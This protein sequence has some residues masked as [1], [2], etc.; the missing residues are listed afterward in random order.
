MAKWRRT[1]TQK[2]CAH[3]CFFLIGLHRTLNVTADGWLLSSWVDRIYHG[4]AY[5]LYWESFCKGLEFLGNCGRETQSLTVYFDRELMKDYSSDSWD[6]CGVSLA[7]VSSLC[8]ICISLCFIFSFI[9]ISSEIFLSKK[10]EFNVLLCL[11]IVFTFYVF[12]CWKDSCI[13]ALFTL[14]NN[15]STSYYFRSNC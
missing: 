4:K 13:Y 11:G 2:I 8:F 6:S 7:N 9:F 5:L 1:T 15:L 12:F 3:I 14:L 10:V